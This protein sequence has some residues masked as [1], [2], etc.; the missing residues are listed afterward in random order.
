M[1]N[2]FENAALTVAAVLF[3]AGAAAML[4][5]RDEEHAHAY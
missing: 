1:L 2:W 5:S 3:I 4:F